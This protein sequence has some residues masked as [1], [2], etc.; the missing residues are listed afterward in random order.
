MWFCDY[1]RYAN[2]DYSILD[3]VSF[4]DDSLAKTRAAWMAPAAGKLGMMDRGVTSSLPP[5]EISNA[6][7]MPIGFC[8][9]IE[10]VEALGIGVFAD[11]IIFRS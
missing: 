1:F 8:L 9:K 5:Q 4:L 7:D 6:I 11:I 2:F 10:L 3:K